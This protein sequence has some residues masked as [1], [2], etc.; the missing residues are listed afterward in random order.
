V[1]NRLQ[2]V[3]F[4]GAKGRRKY[5]P[6][7]RANVSLSKNASSLRY[8]VQQILNNLDT[9]SLGDLFQNRYISPI[10]AEFVCTSLSY[11][12]VTR[13][14][15]TCRPRAEITR[16]FS[17]ASM[18]LLTHRSTQLISPTFRSDSPCILNT[19]FLKHKPLI[20]VERIGFASGRGFAGARSNS[21]A[22]LSS[23]GGRER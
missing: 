20:L 4:L 15:V 17:W 22:D 16:T 21:S 8:R 9:F 2:S 11:V 19:H 1:N 18:Y 12:D 7:T 6:P 23:R 14:G 13:A 3:A 10:L 5:D